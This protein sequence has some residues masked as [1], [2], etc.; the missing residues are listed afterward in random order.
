MAAG[1]DSDLSGNPWVFTF[2]GSTAANT[3]P[4]L[5]VGPQSANGEAFP[6]MYKRARWVVVTGAAGNQ[7][8]VKDYPGIN[9]TSPNPTAQRTQ[10]HLI[11]TGSAFE[12]EQRP[13]AHES[14]VGFDITTFDAGILYLY[15]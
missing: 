10:I 12:A 8:I 7:V 4:Y 3:L 15:F 6:I 14:F 2:N 13:R 5:V 11:A 9:P 1:V